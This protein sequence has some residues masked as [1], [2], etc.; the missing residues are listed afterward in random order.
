MYEAEALGGRTDVT[1][2]KESSEDRGNTK[3]SSAHFLIKFLHDGS[4]FWIMAHA[5]LLL[6]YVWSR[7]LL[8]LTIQLTFLVSCAVVK[9]MVLGQFPETS[10]GWSSL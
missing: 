10:G 6:T 4:V 2:R 9:P 7:A 3:V 1:F 8:Q 5:K